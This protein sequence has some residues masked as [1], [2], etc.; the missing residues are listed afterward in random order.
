MAV[1]LPTLTTYVVTTRENLTALL[2]AEVF[3]KRQSV[4]HE[5][6]ALFLQRR[7]RE[8]AVQNPFDK[9]RAATRAC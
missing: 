9:E 1:Y 6:T 3:H 4:R 7:A 2:R 8:R 5:G